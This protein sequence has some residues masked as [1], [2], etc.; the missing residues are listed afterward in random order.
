MA[1]LLNAIYFLLSNQ[2]KNFEKGYALLSRIDIFIVYFCVLCTI[3][4]TG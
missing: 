4:N 1:F 3:Q 2:S